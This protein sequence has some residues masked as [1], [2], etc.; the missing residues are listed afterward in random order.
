MRA[1][2][3]VEIR[4]GLAAKPSILVRNTVDA[5]D[6]VKLRADGRYSLEDVERIISLLELE[7]ARVKAAKV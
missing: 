6:L 1:L 2:G 4:A 7:K 5:A 3:L